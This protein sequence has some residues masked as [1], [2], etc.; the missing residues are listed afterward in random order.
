MA[1]HMIHD[2]DGHDAV[3][4]AKEASIAAQHTEL[5]RKTVPLVVAP[6]ATHFSKIGIGESPVAR[7]LFVARINRKSD[8]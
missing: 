7:E 5:D 4:V 3:V 8:R 6:A 2:P 1:A